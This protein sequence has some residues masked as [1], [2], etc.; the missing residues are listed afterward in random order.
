[1]LLWTHILLCYSIHFNPLLSLFWYLNFSRLHLW[2][3]LHDSSYAL[4]ICLYHSLNSVR[5]NKIKIFQDNNV[6]FL[7]QYRIYDTLRNIDLFEWKMRFW[8]DLIARS[9]LCFWNVID[10]EPSHWTELRNRD[11]VNILIT[12]IWRFSLPPFTSPLP[13]LSSQYNKTPQITL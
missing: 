12:S 11:I 8:S 2:E 7:P 5:P 9:F 10:S 1:M 3:S 4:W 13:P 6:L